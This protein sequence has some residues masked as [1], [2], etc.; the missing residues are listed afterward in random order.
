MTR[1]REAIEAAFAQ[2]RKEG[3][4]LFAPFHMAC[5][6]S[7][8]ESLACLKA[9]AAAGAGF[10]EIGVPFTD[11][12]ADG[13]SVERAGLRARKAG[14]GLDAALDLTRDLR[15]A[16]VETPVI[17]MGYANPF[18]TK[19]ETGLAEACAEAGVD[20]I[21]AVDLPPEEDADLRAAFAA[22]GLSVI[23]LVA[24]TTGEARLDHA[25]EGAS[26]FLYYVSVAG[27]TGRGRG[28]DEEIAANVARLKSKSDLPVAV[29]FGVRTPEDAL[30]MARLGD[31]VVVGSALADAV[32]EGGPDAA[33]ALARELAEA[34][35]TARA[36]EAAS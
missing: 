10:L 29:G 20:G 33:Q 28:A 32:E 6:P 34:V 8:G 27:V 16:G 7:R 35:R 22:E 18:L 2:G 12:T 26:G 36:M 30:R 19:G 1:G 23:R 31:A 14:G 17:L 25:L 3:R 11:P 13:P 24:P 15:A 5:D 21:I 9:Y 4:A